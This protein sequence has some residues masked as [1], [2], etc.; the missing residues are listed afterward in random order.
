MFEVGKTRKSCPFDLV[1]SLQVHC[2]RMNFTL[3]QIGQKIIHEAVPR[4]S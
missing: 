1:G 2:E 3:H 4:Q